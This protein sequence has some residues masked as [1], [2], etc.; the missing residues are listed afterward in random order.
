[1]TITTIV[2]GVIAA[3]CCAVVL[4]VMRKRA[5]KPNQHRTL[6]GANREVS[7]VVTSSGDNQV[8]PVTGRA[9]PEQ[10]TRIGVAYTFNVPGLG[11]TMADG[12]E[13][14]GEKEEER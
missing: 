3:I 12:G 9:L 6:P 10:L 8:R 2:L 4:A 5:A 14:I 13:P 7:E 1:M 11:L